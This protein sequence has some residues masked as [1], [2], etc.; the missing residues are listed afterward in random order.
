MNMRTSDRK[1]NNDH[2]ALDI[3]NYPEFS[4][5]KIIS[6]NPTHKATPVYEQPNY[7]EMVRGGQ[8]QQQ[9]KKSKPFHVNAN[10]NQ[11]NHTPFNGETADETNNYDGNNANNNLL[12]HEEI[13]QVVIETISQLKKCRSREEQLVEITKIITKWIYV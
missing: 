8:H 12:S 2:N 9:Y 4:G 11:P 1:K 13:T 5:R 10:S 3:K 7:A 6:R